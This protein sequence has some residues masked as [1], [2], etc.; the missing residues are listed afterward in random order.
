MRMSQKP[1]FWTSFFILSGFNLEILEVALEKEQININQ[2]QR[3]SM[4]EVLEY[5]IEGN[6]S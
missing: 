1:C 4:E 2:V 3:L 5:L 6:K